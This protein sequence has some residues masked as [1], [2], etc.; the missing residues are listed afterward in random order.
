MGTAVCNEPQVLPKISLRNCPVD[1]MT[2][3]GYGGP[4]KLRLR[5]LVREEKIGRQEIRNWDLPDSFLRMLC[6]R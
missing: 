3:C 1:L 6:V 2:R 4:N 5:D